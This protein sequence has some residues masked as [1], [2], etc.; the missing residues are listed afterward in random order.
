MDVVS[1]E[2]DL[3][4][5]LFIV[6]VFWNGRVWLFNDGEVLVV[7]MGIEKCLIVESG[8]WVLCIVWWCG[9]ESIFMVLLVV[10]VW[11]KFF[12]I[13]VEMFLGSSGCVVSVILGF[14]EVV[15]GLI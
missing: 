13:F 2:V 11:C 14:C 10:I 8:F 3:S 6:V 9:E 7:I 1:V 4:F 12:M 15:G 5:K